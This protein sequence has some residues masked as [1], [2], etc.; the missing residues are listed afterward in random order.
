M[1]LHR[2]SLTSA[3]IF[4]ELMGYNGF[5]IPLRNPFFKAVSDFCLWNYNASYQ[6]N[7]P[8]CSRY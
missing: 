1:T 2:E 6:W 8:F 4:V 7:L 5:F 3:S